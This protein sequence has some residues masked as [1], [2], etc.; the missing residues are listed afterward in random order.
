MSGVRRCVRGETVSG[1]RRCVGGDLSCLRTTGAVLKCSLILSEILCYFILA[2]GRT[3]VRLLLPLEDRDKKVLQF[4]AVHQGE[5]T[6]LPPP[7]TLQYIIYLSGGP[8]CPW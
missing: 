8:L 1:V 2:E 5:H 6:S 7:S 3:A 4:R